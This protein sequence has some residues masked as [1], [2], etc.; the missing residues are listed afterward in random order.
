[1]AVVAVGDGVEEEAAAQR[2]GL[3][4]VRVQA[5]E[6]LES[7]VRAAVHAAIATAAATATT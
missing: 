7:G 2:L 1:M 5:R 6:D 3:R 4:F